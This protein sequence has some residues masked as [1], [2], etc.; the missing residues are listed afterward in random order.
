ME[1]CTGGE[2]FEY[3]IRKGRISEA[4]SAKIM[5]KILHGIRHLH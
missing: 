3:I 1:L 4:M 5:Q 2:L